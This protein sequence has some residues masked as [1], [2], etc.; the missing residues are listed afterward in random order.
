MADVI[1][2]HSP[3]NLTANPDQVVKK[4][5]QKVVIEF[6]PPLT[7]TGAA[8][9]KES[10]SAGNPASASWLQRTNNGNKIVI[11]VNT[12]TIGFYKYDITVAGVGT[13]DPGIRVI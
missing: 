3:G 8:K 6:D 1:V 9:T 7:W 4:R 2:T 5:G 11:T 13:L 10:P 12:T